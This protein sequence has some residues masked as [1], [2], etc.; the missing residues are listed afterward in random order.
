MNL[1]RN[2]NFKFNNEAQTRGIATE[3]DNR[4]ALTFDFD[5]DG[6]LDILVVNHASTPQL[7][8]NNGAN[9]YDYLRVKVLEANGRE[10]IGA[11]VYLKPTES[12]AHPDRVI[13]IGSTAA[14]LAQG[15]NVAHFGL[16]K[17]LL[18]VH[19]IKIQWPRINRKYNHGNA[20][21]PVVTFYNVPVR[22]TLIVS[23]NIVDKS[24]KRQTRASLKQ[25]LSEILP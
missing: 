7:F 18:V 5:Q 3:E 15:E 1:G 10:S 12:Y 2:E 13:E 22:K 6:D 16:E 14:F 17:D 21:T 25:Q 11:K 23:R 19:R 4:G 8:V 20:P 24:S 9:Y